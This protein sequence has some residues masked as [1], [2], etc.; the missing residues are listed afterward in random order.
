LSAR[1]SA[2]RTSLAH[3]PARVPTKGTDHELQHESRSAEHDRP[4][5]H[6]RDHRDRADDRLELPGS[7]LIIAIIG[8]VAFGGF[9][10]GRWY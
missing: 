6:H 1:S 4:R 3:S 10:R 2:A 7:G 9:T 8:L 5:R